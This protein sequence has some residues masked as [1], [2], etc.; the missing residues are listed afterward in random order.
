MFKVES[1]IFFLSYPEGGSKWLTASLS[2]WH[3]C[4]IFK[5]DNEEETYLLSNNKVTGSCGR[6]MIWFSLIESLSFMSFYG[7]FILLGWAH[8]LV[9]DITSLHI[10]FNHSIQ[11]HHTIS[12]K[13][14]NK[15][16]K[17]DKSFHDETSLINC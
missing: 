8:I 11:P 17:I 7:I 3:I 9:L 6:K 16:W 2:D 1:L 12:L 5:N 10:P 13:T 15:K 14:R 4:L